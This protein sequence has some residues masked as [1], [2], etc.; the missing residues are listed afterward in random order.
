MKTWLH[1]N[2]Y[3]L[4]VAVVLLQM[5]I[6]GG[7]AN[8]LSSLHV[9]PVTEY[10]GISRSQYALGFSLRAVLA[11]VTALVSGFVYR[12]FG[13]KKTTLFALL[14]YVIGHTMLSFMEHTGTFIAALAILGLGNTFCSTA[15]ATYIISKWFRRKRGTVL[16]LVTAST[17]IGG[18]V[19]CI[20]QTQLMESYS[21]RASYLLCGIT[22][23]GDFAFNAPDHS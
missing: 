18:S 2:Y 1:K 16:G 12:R 13:Y 19:L 20:F 14:L 4:I 11:T 17:G 8:N 22:P 3:W 10:L 21:W 15:G 5:A 7:T 6:C 23:G 9:I